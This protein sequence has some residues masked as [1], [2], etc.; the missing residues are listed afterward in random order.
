M[1]DVAAGLTLVGIGVVLFILG[2]LLTRLLERL[3]GALP[4]NPNRR[5][6]YRLGVFILVPVGLIFAGIVSLIL[7]L[8]S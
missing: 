6:A 1:T 7:G 5:R 2:P 8:T 3:P 4:R